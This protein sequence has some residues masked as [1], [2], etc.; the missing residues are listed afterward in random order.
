MHFSASFSL[1]TSSSSSLLL[2]WF[3]VGRRR[4]Q[5][6]RS[7][8]I[9]DDVK[10]VTFLII[11]TPRHFMVHAS[12]ELLLVTAADTL[13]ELDVRDWYINISSL[14]GAMFEHLS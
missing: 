1:T 8:T 5:S 3:G 6:E 2:S 10:I 7:R 4:W 12:G 11:T 14:L 13:H 9:E